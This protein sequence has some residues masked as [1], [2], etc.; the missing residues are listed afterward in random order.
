MGSND[1]EISRTAALT[2]IAKF[3]EKLGFREDEV[4][5]YGRYKAKVR[6]ECEKRLGPPKAKMVVVTAITPTPLGEGKTVTTVGLGQ[7]LRHIG[8]N[9]W[10]CIRQ[11]SAGPVFGIKGGAAGGGR[12]QVV[13]MEDINLHLTG[14]IHAVA[15]A[16][17]LLA[18]FLDNHLNQG[19]ALRIDV[20]GI[21]WGRVV[22][23]NDRALRQVL[24]GMADECGPIRRSHFDI[25]VASEVMAVLALAIS[26]KDLRERLARMIV[27]FR[28]DQPG[29]PLPATAGDLQCA[30]AMAALLREALRPNLMQNMEGGP[31]FVHCGPFGNIA[32]GNSSIVADRIAARMG[33][34]VVTEAG[35]GSD[36][37]FEKF[38]HVKTAAGGMPANAAVVVCTCRA[39]KAHSGLFTVK[40]GVPLDPALAGENLDALERGIAN[41]GHHIRNVRGFGIPAVVAINRF[42]GDSDREIERIRRYALEQGAADAVVSLV[43]AQGGPGGADLAKAVMKA[44]G[45]GKTAKPHFAPDAPIE[46]KIRAIAAKVYNAKG[47]TFSPHAKGRMKRLERLGLGGLAV[48]MAKTHLSTSHDPELKGAPEGFTVPVREIRV[49]AGAGFVVPLLGDITTMPGLPS[50]PAGERISLDDDG[51]VTGLA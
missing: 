27:G 46:E 30:G 22:D 44:L 8:V 50:H 47:V 9:A 39:L 7:A 25:A 10:T 33:D 4:E 1:L 18:A 34:V 35:F 14:D 32:H 38:V 26:P 29:K 24:V 36:L 2:P 23:V 17:N 28:E 51:N 16:H 31:A 41:L 40:P 37:G 15:I 42:P 19:N 12:S 45:E 5:P 21:L 49:S 3:A 11:P 20:D 43:H 13:P 6:L 48:C